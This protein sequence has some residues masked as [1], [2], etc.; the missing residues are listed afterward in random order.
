MLLP[1]HSSLGSIKLFPHFG[2]GAQ[3]F[4][5]KLQLLQLN[6][7][8]ENPKSKQLSITPNKLPSHF[9]FMFIAPSPQVPVVP[10]QLLVSSLH[11]LHFIVPPVNKFE[12]CLQFPLNGPMLLPS[13]S[14]PWSIMLLPH[15]GFGVHLLVSIKQFDAHVK[16]PPPKPKSRQLSIAP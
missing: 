10:K 2:V 6:I 15:N 16:V 11:A 5:S 3:P 13:H 4:V 12:Y 9:S 7:P 8:P 14:S 1:S